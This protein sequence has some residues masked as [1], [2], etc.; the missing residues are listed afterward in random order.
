M[1]NGQDTQ[2]D[3]ALTAEQ[4]RLAATL[5]PSQVA[6]IDAALLR[7]CGPRSRKLAMVVG[8]AMHELPNRIHGLPDVFYARR[9]AALVASG[10]LQAIGDLRRMRY[11]EVRLA[12]PDGSG[13]T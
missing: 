12:V 10:R 11:S 5:T 7:A 8:T 6:E 4:E 1:A 2:L 3:S 13:E 9:V